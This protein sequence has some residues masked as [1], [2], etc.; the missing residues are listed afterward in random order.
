MK[1]II[2]ILGIILMCS[3]RKNSGDKL[4]NIE[5]DKITD[6]VV[7]Y[8]KN[9]NLKRKGV[10]LKNQ[11]KGLWK[12]YDTLGNL[13]DLLEYKIIESR[14]YLNRRWTLN[15][16]QDTIGG[17]YYDYF[18][19][20]TVEYRGIQKLGILLRRPFLSSLSEVYFLLPEN[21]SDLDSTFTD[22]ENKK[23]DTIKS[24]KKNNLLVF[25]PFIANSIGR[26]TVRGVLV[27]KFSENS[28]DKEFVT[29]EY[30]FE[31]SFYVRDT[32]K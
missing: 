28:L 23:Y 3:C 4:E 29:S 32:V 19:Y 18:M 22:Y 17:T 1:K 5:R 10:F 14:S 26:N 21:Y 25:F 13:N 15:E 11:K 9:G 31:H 16:S 6:T 7:F 30:F 2:I 8:H 24:L 20:D 27:E 12:H